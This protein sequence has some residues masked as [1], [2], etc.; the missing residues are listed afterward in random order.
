MPTRNLT[1]WRIVSDLFHANLGQVF[2]KDIDAVCGLLITEVHDS[3]TTHLKVVEFTGGTSKGSRINT[4]SSNFGSISH[5][6]I[7]SLPIPTHN[8][9]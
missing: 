4:K 2:E 7:S 8:T 5:L 9:V 3:A 6:L 1:H